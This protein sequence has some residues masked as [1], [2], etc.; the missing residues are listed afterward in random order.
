MGVFLQ[1]WGYSPVTKKAGEVF[2]SSAFVHSKRCNWL[3][4]NRLVCAVTECEMIDGAGLSIA[5]IPSLGGRAEHDL[6]YHAVSKN[7]ADLRYIAI[8]PK[9]E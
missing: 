5:H 4:T 9:N 6:V 8:L 2:I 1:Q 7:I 3:F